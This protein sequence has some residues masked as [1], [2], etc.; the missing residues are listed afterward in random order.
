LRPTK[1]L[2]TGLAPAV[3]T[4]AIVYEWIFT[5]SFDHVLK[6]IRYIGQTIQDLDARTRQ[7]KSDSSRDHKDV[8]LHALWCA[9]P[10]DDHWQIIPVM[11][12]RFVDREKAFEWMDREEKRLIAEHGGPLCD[13]DSSLKQTLNLTTGGQGNPQKR[14]DGIFA[15]SRKRLH[16]VWP[17]FKQFYARK[18][19]LCIKINHVEVV[20]GVEVNLGEIV[21]G[22]RSRKSFMNH[23]DFKN[24][25][26]ER[27]F[28]HD[29]NQ[30][31]FE[32]DVWP[33]FKQFYDRENHLRIKQRHVEEVDGDE[34]NLGNI[35]SG[36]RSRKSFM[37]HVDFKEWLDERGFV[38]DE[39]L[40]H[41]ELDVWPAF[42]Q[43][44]AREAHLRIQKDHVEIVSGIK[45]NLG[46]IVSTIR[47]QQNFV[48]QH[49]D[50]KKWLDECG[51]VYDENQAHLELDVWPV[52]KQFYL[53]E[54]HLRIKQDHVEIFSGIKVNLGR[55]VQHIRSRRDF[56][57]YTDFRMWLWCACFQMF[58]QKGKTAAEQN[59][60]R[61]ETAMQL[62]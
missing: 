57:H 18:K 58:A 21:S 50:F 27:G 19:H 13:M 1:R 11:E 48:K 46:I 28:V 62:A 25:L 54:K 2:K 44:Y 20:D 6:G 40:A 42:K 29:E 17:A 55:I 3:L 16:G 15:Y 5:P 9:Y 4:L 14:S 52:F 33:A 59:R 43:F 60:K 51:F 22:I 32:R 56:L 23:A 61:W 53:R 45:V 39:N 41:V 38:Y 12:K 10:H 37:H 35:V 47:S 31:H 36:I 30:A 7:H 26:D 24:W 49:V 8:G 34:V